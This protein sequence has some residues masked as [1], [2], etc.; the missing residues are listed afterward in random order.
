MDGDGL[1]K[2][3]DFCEVRKEVLP[4][5]LIVVPLDELEHQ[6]LVYDRCKHVSHLAQLL[7]QLEHERH[8]SQ[9]ESCGRVPDHTFD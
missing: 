8:L 6:Q 5:R 7:K 3:E 9:L 1:V 2:G 4:Y